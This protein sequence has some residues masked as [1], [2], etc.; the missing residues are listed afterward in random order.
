MYHSD[1][2]LRCEWLASRADE[3]LITQSMGSATPY[4]VDASSSVPPIGNGLNAK[5]FARIYQDTGGSGSWSRLSIDPSTAGN[6]VSFATSPW[7]AER[8]ADI[9][10]YPTTRQ[11]RIRND[12]GGGGAAACTGIVYSQGY[13]FNYKGTI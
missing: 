6:W 7:V 10:L 2:L 12:A 11:F 5:L 3:V 1:G 8:L 4:V 13:V 9:P